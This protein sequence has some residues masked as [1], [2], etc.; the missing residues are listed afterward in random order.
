MSQFVQRSGY[1]AVNNKIDANLE[2]LICD[3]EDLTNVVVQLIQLVDNGTVVLVTEYT[4]DGTYWIPLDASTDAT[5]IGVGVG[6]SV[7]FTLSDAAGM[8]IPAKQVR[9]RSSTHS[10]T[11]EYLMRAAGWRRAAA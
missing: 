5:D 8:P 4:L 7:A 10:G 2:S 6:S 11:G 3:V 1:N 9:V